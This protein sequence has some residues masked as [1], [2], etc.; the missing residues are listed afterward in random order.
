MS[1]GIPADILTEV[2]YLVMYTSLQ[3]FTVAF[4]SLCYKEYLQEAR[5]LLHTVVGNKF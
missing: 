1:T 5:N 3:T 2:K 4:I